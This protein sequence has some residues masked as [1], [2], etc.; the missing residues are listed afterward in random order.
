MRNFASS[1]SKLVAKCFFE[2]SHSASA[3]QKAQHCLAA[4]KGSSLATLVFAASSSCFSMP[5][6]VL[7]SFSAFTLKCNFFL[8]L[9]L[10]RPLLLFGS[11]LDASASNSHCFFFALASAVSCFFLA[12]AS[13]RRCLCWGQSHQSSSDG[14]CA[15]APSSTPDVK[16]LAG[17]QLHWRETANWTARRTCRA[18]A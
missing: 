18:T 16:P 15:Q 17:S 14:H 10:L 3:K 2:S 6:G 8:S 13:S 11:A 4:L 7:S 12:S 5:G 9:R 1:N